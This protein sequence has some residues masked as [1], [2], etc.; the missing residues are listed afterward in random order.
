MRDNSIKSDNFPNLHV[1]NNV[2]STANISQE[3]LKLWKGAGER[4]Y[5]FEIQEFTPSQGWNGTI[6]AVALTSAQG[7]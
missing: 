7:R 5:K 6:S 2:N 1:S 4:G 3:E